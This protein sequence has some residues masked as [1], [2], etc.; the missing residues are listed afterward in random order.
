MPPTISGTLQETAMW[1]DIIQAYA[2]ALYVATMHRPVPPR[3]AGRWP[4]DEPDAC[5]ASPQSS[6]RFRR[7]GRW[8]ARRGVTDR[9]APGVDLTAAKGCG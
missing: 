8:L 2:D 4:R 1:I 9:L 6:T 7:L 3:A 5:Q